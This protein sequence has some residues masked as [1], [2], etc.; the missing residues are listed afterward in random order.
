M[1]PDYGLRLLQD[2]VS[3][4]VDLFFYDFTLFSITILGEGQYSTMV[5]K[6]HDG[7][8]FALSLDFDR[9]QLENI[10][11]KAPRAV[12]DDVERKLSIEPATPRSIELVEPI[13]VPVRA[14]LGQLQRNQT[15]VFVPL[16]C[17]EV[18][19]ATTDAPGEAQPENAGV[20]V[21]SRSTV[22]ALQPAAT[23]ATLRTWVETARN[24]GDVC[25][26]I[27]LR[28]SG[29]DTDTREIWEI[30]EV[31]R[32]VHSLDQGFPFWFYLADLRS[33]FLKV[34]AFCLCRVSTTRPGATAINQTDF[35]A[36]LERHFGAMNQLLEHWSVSDEENERVSNEVLAYFERAR[37]LN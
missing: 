2:G 29:Y 33:D 8:W 31:R 35:A 15:E 20:I 27:Q 14:R 17:Q 26:S 22:E 23:L 24:A 16:V 6:P 13:R 3:R 4:N 37:I 30:P 19:R 21:V 7:Q 18:L 10:L 12:R 5:E 36:F 28:F 32:F 1:K 9:R 34:L 11:M 25:R